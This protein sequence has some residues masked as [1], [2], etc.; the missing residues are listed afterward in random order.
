MSALCGS[1]CVLAYYLLIIEICMLEIFLLYHHCYC[2]S[3]PIKENLSRLNVMSQFMFVFFFLVFS[4]LWLVVPVVLQ[5]TTAFTLGE[6]VHSSQQISRLVL[7]LFLWLGTI[8][9]FWVCGS[10]DMNC[11]FL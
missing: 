2:Q 3:T 1:V 9:A 7:L 8:T 5:H 11:I 10:V 6:S 4:M